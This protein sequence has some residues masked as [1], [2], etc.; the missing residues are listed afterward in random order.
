MS[1]L[2][3]EYWKQVDEMFL[4]ESSYAQRWLTLLLKAGVKQVTTVT[5][6][7]VRSLM[8]V[9]DAEYSQ[10]SDLIKRVVYGP[11]KEINESTIYE[12]KFTCLHNKRKPILGFNFI[13]YEKPSKK[14]IMEFVG[15][16]HFTNLCKE[17]GIPVASM[18]AASRYPLVTAALFQANRDI[19]TGK[20]R[21]I[22]S[23]RNYMLKVIENSYEYL[24][25]I[26]NF[27]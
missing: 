17:F 25:P 7:Q 14:T 8:L 10:K 22:I 27:K 21:I 24:E 11:I 9:D 2:E 5:I 26:I 6:E 16:D 18:L 13:L 12:V 1:E 20:T 19:K 15:A 3:S 4:L 23:Q